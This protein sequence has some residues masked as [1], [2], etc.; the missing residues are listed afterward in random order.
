ML[1]FQV[2]A[3]ITIGEDSGPLSISLAPAETKSLKLYLN[4]SPSACGNDLPVGILFE[5]QNNQVRALTHF[6]VPFPVEMHPLIFDQPGMI[7]YP[8]TLFNYSNESPKVELKIYSRRTNEIVYE[9]HKT[10]SAD[11]WQKVISGFDFSLE[12]GEYDVYVS[13]LGVTKKSKISIMSQTGSVKVSEKDLNHDG[14]PEIIMEN[15]QIKATLLLFGGRVI[16]YIVKNRD[17]N[18]LFKLWP[19]KPP[20]A[21]TPRGV[22]AFY[23]WGGLEEF[24]GY[25]YIGGHIV[26]KYEIIEDSGK[27]GRVRLWANVHGSKIEK[28]ISLYGENELLEVRYAMDD[29]VP[30]ITVIGIN[31]LIE[32]G[33]STG[34][35]DVYYFPADKLEQRRPEMGR[36]YGDMF[37]LKEGWAAGYDT[38]MDISLV[39]GYPVNDA[40][41]M[42]L[43]NNHPN[44]TPTPYYYT[45]LQP[46]LK[47]KPQT[48]TYF[49]YYLY[50]KSGNWKEA[51]EDF[52]NL[53][54]VTKVDEGN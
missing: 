3:D 21:G 43:W 27:R 38:E 49:S 30:S 51:L 17:E 4:A 29:I 34:P 2:S 26:F 14:I 9:D 41:F 18:L 42:H 48:T 20:W 35:E 5:T 19:Q 31:P 28:I 23:P 22:R 8:V 6:Q 12:A 50:G 54:L 7:H 40:M 32:I 10:V 47:I 52:R 45:E 36:Y 11:K 25:P 16:E 33:P 46:W 1:K 44:N 39:I 13:S 53:G 15:S 24:T 37:F